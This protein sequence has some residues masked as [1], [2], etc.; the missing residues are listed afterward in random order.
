MNRKERKKAK[1]E[2]R[3]GGGRASNCPESL[4]PCPFSLELL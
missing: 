4:K 3:E 1:R 2:T